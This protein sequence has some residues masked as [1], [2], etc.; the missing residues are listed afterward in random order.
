M[1]GNQPDYVIVPVRAMAR[2]G[3][4]TGQAILMST[5]WFCGWGSTGGKPFSVSTEEF[6]SVYG[7]EASDRTIRRMVADLE[8]RGLIDR[9]RLNNGLF[10]Y[11]FTEEG[12]EMMVN[13]SKPHGHQ[14]QQAGQSGAPY[15]HQRRPHKDTSGRMSIIEINKKGIYKSTEKSSECPKTLEDIGISIPEDHFQPF[16]TLPEGSKKEGS[17]KGMEEKSPD[18]QQT[19]EDIGISIPEDRYKRLTTLFGERSTKAYLARYA[20]WLSRQPEKRQQGRDAYLTVLN[21]MRRDGLSE[22]KETK[23]ILAC[24]HCGSEDLTAFTC[25]SCGG[26]L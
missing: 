16:T 12:R 21:W 4:T 25:L 10:E 20:D 3:L 13:A 22:R 18:H 19:L 17:K 23:R 24:P 11:S 26:V 2:A 7:F 1:N 15:G 14:W 8:G 9:Q 5:L 6:V